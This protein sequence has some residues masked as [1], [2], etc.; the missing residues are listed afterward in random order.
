VLQEIKYVTS[1]AAQGCIFVAGGN[2][3]YAFK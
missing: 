2:R 1:I 3:V